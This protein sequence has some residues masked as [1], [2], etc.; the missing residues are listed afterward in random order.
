RSAG[1]SVIISL[2]RPSATSMPTD[3]REQLGGVFCFGVKGSPTADLALPDDVRDAG[4][5]PEAWENRKPG[6]NY[7]VA[8]GVDEERYA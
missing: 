8:P 4:A 2:Q 6:Y 3:V 7:L 5:R 1:I